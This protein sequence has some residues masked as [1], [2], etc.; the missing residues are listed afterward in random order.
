[1]I[2][3]ITECNLYSNRID[4]CRILGPLHKQ[5]SYKNVNYRGCIFIYIHVLPHSFLLKS[6][7]QTTDFIRNGWAEH[8]YMNMH[9]S[10]N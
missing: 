6:T 1:M 9:P 3:Q 2:V 4:K 7:L 10:P 8:D 5:D